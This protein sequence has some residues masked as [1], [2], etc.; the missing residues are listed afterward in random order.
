MVRKRNKWSKSTMTQSRFSSLSYSIL[1]QGTDNLDH[2]GVANEFVSKRY[3]TLPCCADEISQNL[4]KEKELFFS[5]INNHQNKVHP[6]MF[7]RKQLFDPLPLTSV[8]S[9]HQTIG[10]E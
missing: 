9:L 2:A 3:A 10:N 1:S 4:Q 5:L 6:V 8:L 7:F